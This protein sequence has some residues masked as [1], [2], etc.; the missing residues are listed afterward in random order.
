MPDFEA[1][2][3]E[4]LKNR[5]ELTR[6]ELQRRIEEKKRTVGAGYLTDQGALYLLAGEFGVPLQAAPAS[7]MTIKDLY[8]GANDLTV[9]ARVLAVYPPATYT[10]KKDGSKGKYRRL[11]LFDGNQSARLTVWDQQVDEIERLGLEPD[12][13]VRVVSAYVRQGLDGKPNLNLGSRG[14]IELVVDSKVTD[15]L[16]TLSDAS[17]RLAKISQE[18]RFVGVECVVKSEPRYSE[19]VRSDGSQGSLFQFGATAQGGKDEARVVIW[20]PSERPDLRP[21]QKVVVT[22]LRSRRTAAGDFELY[23]DAGTVILAAPKKRAM[24]LRVVSVS[25]SPQGKSVLALGPD[26]KVRMISIGKGV[27][28]PIKGD[29]ALVSADSESGGVLVCST[30]ESVLITHE[31]TVP[32]AA[33]LTTKLKDAREEN[34]QVMVEVIALSQGSVDDVRLRDGSTAR[35]GEFLVG[36]DTGEMRVVGWREQ[37]DKIPGIQPGERVRIVGATVKA[38][39]MG[40]WNLQLSGTSVV[41]RLRA[42]D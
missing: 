33:G 23:G 16:K 5:P 15:R 3:G 38:T 10:K 35:L 18:R 14:K 9:T 26:K 21:G 27:V 37:S 17:E 30:P 11:A 34:A 8:I 28:V 29:I 22:N 41:E 19:F 2:V 13:P 39:K 1:L 36:D 31:G 4:L 6:D 12:A 32:D 20:S 7:D 42:R 24:E 40:G 25:E